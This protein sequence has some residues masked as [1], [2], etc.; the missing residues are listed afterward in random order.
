MTASGVSVHAAEH[1][2]PIARTVSLVL[3]GLVAG[4]V[5]YYVTAV[6]AALGMSSGFSANPMS[7]VLVAAAGVVAV[8]VGWRWRTVGI[9]AGVVVLLVVAF[10]IVERLS[11]SSSAGDWASATNA[12]A[13]GAVTGYPAMLG[14]VLVTI[15]ALHPRSAPVD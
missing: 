15:S 9:T 12:V 8:V 4:A 1:R 7:F 11:W 10:A 13:L 3:V 14:A 6:G 2:R 5:L